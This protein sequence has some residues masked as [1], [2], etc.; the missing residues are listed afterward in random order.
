MEEKVKIAEIDIGVD[1]LVK[2]AGEA[3]QRLAEISDEQKKLKKS[4]DNLKN[5]SADQLDQFTKN[6]VEAKNLRKTYRDSTKVIDA[7]INIQ[8]QDIR[9]KEQ[10]RN[11]NS[12]LIAIANKLDATNE[13]QAKTLEKVNA[14]I[15]KNTDFIK[16]NASEYE[17]TKINVGNYKE[18]ITGALNEL[19]IFGNAQGAVNSITKASGPIITFVSTN[20]KKVREDYKKATKETYGMSKAQIAAH[21]TS[22]TL[23]SGLRILKIALAATGIG[24]VVIALGSLITYFASTQEGINKVNMVLTPLKEA[25]KAVTGSVQEL[26]AAFAK[27][28]TGDIKG[29]LGDIKEIGAEMKDNIKEAVE[30]GK[31]METIKQNLSK[32]EAKYI[33]QQARLNK[34]FEQQKKLSDDTTKST[35]EREKAAEKAIDLQKEISAGSIERIKQEAEILRLKQMS[36]DTSDADKAELATKLAEID[37]ALQEE[38]A[39]TTEAQ[40]KLNSIRKEGAAQAIA[41]RQKIT[42]NAIQKQKE[43][44]DLYIA[45]QGFKAKALQEELKVAENVSKRKLDILEAEFKAGKVSKTAYESEKLDITNEFAE[46]Q[47]NAAVSNAEREMDA[48]KANHQSKIDAN[49][50]LNDQLF[51]QEQERLNRIAEAERAFQTEKLNQGAVNQQEYNEAINQ[52]NADNQIVQD[53]LKAQRREDQKAK[54]AIDLENKKESEAERWFNQFELESQRLEQDRQREI[55]EAEKTGADITLIKAKYAKL[56]TD[57]EKSKQEAKAQMAADTLD[58]I[59]QVLGEETAAGK[60]AALAQAL[61]NTYLGI[62]AGVKLGWPAMIPAV[63]AAS[64][65]GFGAVKN[66]TKTKTPKAERGISMDIDGPSHSQGGITLFDEAGN[67]IVEAQGGEKMVI[68]KRE[69]S[70]ELGALS[71]LNQ[72]HGGVNLNTPVA[73]ANNGGAVMRSSISGSTGGAFKM[74][75]NKI[76]QAVGSYVAQNINAVQTVVPVDSITSLAARTASVERGADL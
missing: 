55:V 73:Y 21:L 44:L 33:T 38:A 25:F 45:N 4:T 3:K 60:A 15:D 41:V 27:L 23:T 72:K 30:R 71:A 50:F 51:N 57:I 34:E 8:N 26:G 19:G 70:K 58:S 11:A 39:K 76:G 66:I 1:K 12:K 20:L 22:T 6:D 48:F 28:F 16:D 75:Y 40:N 14:E 54:E 29:F 36:N 59:S 2:K 13:D 7:Y 47:A 31:E 17:K 49:Q 64:A 10:A 53:E 46:K 43:E 5:A 52:I 69:A 74:D 65:T 37:K 24:L 56:Q 68:L 9:T 67:P 32:T 42:D 35:E 18:A 61:I 63:A 62:T